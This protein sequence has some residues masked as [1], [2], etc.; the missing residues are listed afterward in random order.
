MRLALTIT[1]AGT[2]I[3]GLFPNLFINGANWALGLVQGTQH[4]ARMLR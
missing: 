1:A 4:M 3:I 2:V